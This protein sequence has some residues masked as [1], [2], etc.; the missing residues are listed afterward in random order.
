MRILIVTPAPAGSRT[1]NRVT[2]LRWARLL[3]ALGHRVALA[4]AY[5]DQSCDLLIAL[6]ARRSF[7]SVARFRRQHP[8]HPVVVALTGTDLYADLPRSAVAR[9]SLELATRLVTLQP[10]G[11]RALPARVRPRARAIVQSAEAPRTVRPPSPR[12]F[13]VCVLGH[14]RPVKDPFRAALAVRRLPAGSRIRLLHVGAARSAGLAARARAEQKK[15]A[16]YQW[17]GELSRGRALR[18]LARARLLVLTS[19]LEGGANVISE[20]IACGVPVV[21][22][23]IAGSIGL[24]GADYPGYFRVGDTRGLAALLARAERDPLFYRVLSERCARLKPLVDPARE[25]ASWAR[26]L[27]ELG[28]LQMA[29]P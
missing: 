16:R 23:R 8:A 28:D 14:L 26:L 25:R 11:I 21:S 19:R 3:R 4:L 12:A 1:G 10:L 2:A 24:L 17:L 22:T 27:G 15:N 5:R 29:K 6:H 7:P 20:A 9:R 13:E 18:V